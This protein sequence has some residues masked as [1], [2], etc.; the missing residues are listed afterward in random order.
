MSGHRPPSRAAL[1]FV[2]LLS[3]AAIANAATSE[4]PALPGRFGAVQTEQLPNGLRVVLAPDPDAA[5]VDVSVWYEAGLRAEKSGQ[6]GIAHLFEHL[7]FDGSAHVPRRGHQARI[8]AVGGNA[9]A[10]TTA[11]GICFFETVP[12]SGLQTALELEAD[13]MTGLTLDAARLDGERTAIRIERQ[14]PGLN[15]PLQVGLR[16]AAETA[17]GEH[18]YH[19]PVMGSDAELAKLTVKDVEA[20]YRARFGPR[21]AVLIIVGRFDPDEAL[22]LAHRHFDA[23]RGGE[24][25]AATAKPVAPTAARRRWL[26]TALPFRLLVMGWTGPGRDDPDGVPLALLATLLARGDA[27]RLSGQLIEQQRLCFFIEGDVD[28]RRDA[29]LF[30]L[31]AGLQP[32]ADSAA[33][34]H[35][36][37]QSVE[38]VAGEP[39]ADAELARA[40]KQ[41]E[42]R[43]LFGWQSSR[44]RAQAVGSAVAMGGDISDPVRQLERVRSCTP[45]DVQRTAARWLSTPRRSVVWLAARP[46]SGAGAGGGAR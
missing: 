33:V 31:V 7:M 4:T 20:W 23:L 15:S 34:E 39:P 42:N 14:Q 17:Y 40:R 37:V 26:R 38:R 11:D 30:T 16:L 21:R 2:L 29:S 41:L 28:A 32:G 10:V 45:A 5:A 18:P 35:A 8:D 1:A 27:A 19:S 9:G 44:G 43:I 22:R 24:V 13:R 36:L 25:A 12:A 3:I 6:R 46:E